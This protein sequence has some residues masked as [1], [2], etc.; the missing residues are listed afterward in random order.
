MWRRS[1]RGPRQVCDLRTRHGLASVQMV[2]VGSPAQELGQFVISHLAPDR[3]RAAER[4]LVSGYHRELTAALRARGRADVADTYTLDACW[5]EYVAGGIGRWGL[6]RALAYLA[7]AMP[8][9]GQFFHDQ[10]A[11]FLRDHCPDPAT[12]PMPRV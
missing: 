3:R 4:R 6:V 9:L 12:A 8:Q 10:L 5:A 2:G 1:G 7:K 11:A